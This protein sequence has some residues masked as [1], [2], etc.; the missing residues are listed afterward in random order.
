MLLS[1]LPCPAEKRRELQH[2]DAR[3]LLATA[4]PA[5][6]PSPPPAT[7]PTAP[8]LAFLHLRYLLDYDQPILYAYEM[9]VDS[10]HQR[11]GTGAHLMRVAQLMAVAAGMACVRLTVFKNN[12]A[13]L[14]L[15]KK[16]LGYTADEASRADHEGEDYEVLSK[17]NPKFIA[18]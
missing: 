6:A 15:Y 4:Y 3:F 7:L 8:P 12:G 2:P 1:V 9:Q 14:Q 11:L 5:S 13:G 17:S 10:P 18:G 16:T